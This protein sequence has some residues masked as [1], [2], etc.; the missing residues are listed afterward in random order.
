MMQEW[1]QVLRV[2]ENGNGNGKRKVSQTEKDISFFGLQ[3]EAVTVKENK[4]V[5]SKQLW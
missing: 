1:F 4:S 2:E 5:R 3:E